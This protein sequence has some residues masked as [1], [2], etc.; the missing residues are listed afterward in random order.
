MGEGGF[1]VAVFAA[2]GRG[3]VAGCEGESGSEAEELVATGSVRVVDSSSMRLFTRWAGKPTSGRNSA[4]A[5]SLST[6][7]DELIVKLEALERERQDQSPVYEL[8]AF[9]VAP[10]YQ[11]CGVGVRVLEVLEWQVGGAVAGF[12]ERRDERVIGFEVEG[13]REVRR[14]DAERGEVVSARGKMVLVA[15]REIGNEGYYRRRGYETIG[16]GVLPVG[17]WGSKV[18]CTTVFMEKRV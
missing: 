9:G 7:Y 16:T 3:D 5:R 12:E 4:D 14:G 17:T 11:G 1:T 10:G 18:E 8:C 15:I 13:V 6:H 2:R